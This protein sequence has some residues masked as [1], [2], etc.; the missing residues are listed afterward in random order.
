MTRP[1]TQARA[2]FVFFK[3]E[4]SDGDRGGYGEGEDE[5]QRN[6]VT[7]GDSTPGCSR[8]L[9]DGQESI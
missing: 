6:P 5:F 1:A 9:G 4:P 2:G 3:G 8:I 7:K